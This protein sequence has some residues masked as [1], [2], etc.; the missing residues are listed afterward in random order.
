MKS[1]PDQVITGV[2]P[3]TGIGVEPMQNGLPLPA[4]A[5]SRRVPS[6]RSLT[7]TP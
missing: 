2:G 5:S 1:H 7:F 6:Q 4:N 3:T